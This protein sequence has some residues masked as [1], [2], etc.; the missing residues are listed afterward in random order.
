M[1]SNRFTPTSRNNPCPICEKTDGACRIL[2]DDTIF[3]HSFEDA[4]KGEKINGF[5]CVKA[6]TGHTATFRPDNSAEWSEEQKQQWQEQ[7]KR[8]NQLAKKEQQRKRERS[9]SAQARHE[10]YSK[11][12][13]QLSLKGDT[14]ADLQKRGFSQEEIDNCGFKSVIKSQPLAAQIDSKLP[15]INKDGQSLVI[16]DEGYVCPMRDF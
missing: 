7:Q 5:V 6:A 4:R 10:H 14:V 16:V 15:G 1:P 2:T 9:L 8:N 11:I 12:L 3:C 13:A